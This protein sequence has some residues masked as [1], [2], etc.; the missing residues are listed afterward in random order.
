MNRLLAFLFV[1][2]FF[3]SPTLVFASN[4]TLSS[5]QNSL[6]Q[7]EEFNVNVGF[8]IN[9]VD[10]TSYYL[11]GVFYKDGT[12]NYCGYTWNGNSW[13]NGP[14]SGNGWDQLF[15]VTVYQSSWSGQLKAKL[16]ASD[17]G[18]S[19]S[20]EYKFKIQRYTGNGSS[21]FDDQNILTLNLIIP[22]ATPTN[23]PTPTIA[24]TPTPTPTIKPSPTAT[25]I[26]SAKTVVDSANTI[27]K[28]KGTEGEV[29]GTSSKVTPT[30][31]PTPTPNETFVKG[32]SSPIP[33]VFFIIGGIAVITAGCGILLFRQWR[34]QKDE[35]I[36][37]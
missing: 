28:V 32:E 26:P 23:S 1:I 31:T 16:D 9:T 13:Y 7:N 12:S 5:S 37:L 15:P 30:L 27:Q 6:T 20:G 25:A 22:S 19:S 4:L 18:C 8:N 3:L 35:G 33:P 21:S 14:Y 11:R 34:K 17:S 29:L 24:K 36:G 10:G 2:I